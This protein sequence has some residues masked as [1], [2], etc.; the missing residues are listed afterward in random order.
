[1]EWNDLSTVEFDVPAGGT[2]KAD[3]KIETKK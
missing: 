1:V 2:D 3:F